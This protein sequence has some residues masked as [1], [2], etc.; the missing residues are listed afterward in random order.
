MGRVHGVAGAGSLCGRP[1]IGWASRE[2]K[3]RKTRDDSP[4]NNLLLD[5]LFFL[6][7]SRGNEREKEQ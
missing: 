7:I 5:S 2:Y 1:V 4:A 3:E 6:S